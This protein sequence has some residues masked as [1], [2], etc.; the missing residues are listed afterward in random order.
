MLA[1]EAARCAGDQEYF[2]EYHDL[3][4]ANVDNPNVP[5]LTR[6]SFD[7]FAQYLDLDMDAFGTCMDEHT[8]LAAV[9]ESRQQASALGVSGT[10]TILLNGEIVSG[11]QTYD[12]LLQ[13]IEDAAS[14]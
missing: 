13:M 10:P 1:A 5:G 9:N 6:A 12:E 4:F 2:W 8:H 14:E 3:I 7:L 11:I